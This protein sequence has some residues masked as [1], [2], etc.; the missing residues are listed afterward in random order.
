MYD[1]LTGMV[2]VGALINWA[3]ICATYIR[4]RKACK[5]QDVRVVEASKSPL[6]PMLAW[7]GLVWTIFLSTALGLLI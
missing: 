6:Q 5:V 7:Y 4:F 3:I 1:F 2:T